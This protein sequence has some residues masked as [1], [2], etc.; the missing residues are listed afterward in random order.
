M[1]PSARGAAPLIAD[2]RAI[3]LERLRIVDD[4]PWSLVTTYIPFALGEGLLGEDFTTESLYGLLECKYGVTISRG[5]RTIEAVAADQL[6]ADALGVRPGSPLLLLT[7]TAYD[8]AGAP[9]EHFVARHRAD[10]TSF[11][12]S[13][14]RRR[15]GAAAGIAPA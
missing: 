14:T 13:V 15:S 6:A 2:E 7:S 1:P 10:A 8:D 12:V 4:R 5:R 3:V 11:E 9:V